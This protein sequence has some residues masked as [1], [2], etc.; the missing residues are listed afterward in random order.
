MVYPPQASEKRERQE[1]G[2]LLILLLILTS[3]LQLGRTSL[4]VS[5]AGY[6]APKLW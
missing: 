1:S 5:S 2:G 3:A 6:S 4:P